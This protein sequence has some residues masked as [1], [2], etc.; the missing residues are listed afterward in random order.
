MNKNGTL[1][2][3]PGRYH[4]GDLR[5]QLIESTRRLVEEKGPDQLSVSEASR[6]AGVSSAAPYKHFKDKNDLLNAVALDGLIRQHAQMRDALADLPA[7]SLERII[8]LGRVYVDFAR[9]EPAVFRLMF[10]LSDRH[11]KDIA[12]TKMGEDTFGAVQAEVAAF[13]G[14]DVVEAQDIQRAFQLWSYVHGLSF[15]L[16]DG[17]VNEMDI[18]FDLDEMLKR[19]AVQVMLATV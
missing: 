12:L 2:K 6:L 1:K 16:I 18:E 7:K 3:I 17:K 8:A 11:G 5:S 9:S 4:H 19:T 14:S 15:L 10:G 13:R